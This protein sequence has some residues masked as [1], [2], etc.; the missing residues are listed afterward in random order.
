MG[1]APWALRDSFRELNTIELDL[2][3]RSGPDGCSPACRRSTASRATAASGCPIV[4]K[5]TTFVGCGGYL[6]LVEHDVLRIH[7]SS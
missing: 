5:Y 4:K 3:L 2:R 7:R 6:F 1:D